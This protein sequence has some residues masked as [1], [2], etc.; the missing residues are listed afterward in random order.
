MCAGADGHETLCV[1]RLEQGAVVRVV[2]GVPALFL[3]CYT[4][5]PL[6]SL[7][8]PQIYLQRRGAQHASLFPPS[9]SQLCII[10]IH[11]R[12]CQS[13]YSTGGSLGTGKDSELACW[14]GLAMSPG[15]CVSVC[16]RRLTG[17]EWCLGGV[18]WSGGI[19]VLYVQCGGDRVLQWWGDESRCL[20]KREPAE[21]WQ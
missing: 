15:L 13:A 3:Q 17:M 4:A 1:H 18:L 6:A 11:C 10:D 8:N 7:L 5:P 2:P 21:S 9:A 12:E 19:H 20:Y 16:C 14:L